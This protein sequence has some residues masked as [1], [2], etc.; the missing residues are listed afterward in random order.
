MLLSGAGKS[1]CAALRYSSLTNDYCFSSVSVTWETAPRK[2]LPKTRVIVCFKSILSAWN[3][4][5]GNQH[6]TNPSIALLKRTH[7]AIAAISL[8]ATIRKIRKAL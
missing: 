5:G 6:H 7:T 2:K 8:R 1:W 4:E 3:Y